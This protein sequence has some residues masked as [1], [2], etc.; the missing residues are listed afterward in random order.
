MQRDQ[1]RDWVT[2]KVRWSDM[3]AYRHV[4]NARYF[5]YLE[6]ARIHLFEQLTDGGWMDTTTGPVLA[7]VAM[8]FRLPVEYPATLEV[9][10]VLVK[11]GRSS[12]EL[13]H[14]IYFQDTE[15]LVGDGK[16]VVVW[17]DRATGKATPLTDA[18]RRKLD[19]YAAPG[20][21]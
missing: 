15:T 7:S 19:R 14:G 10:T 9:G 5:T 4:N 13:H 1:F 11:M 6:A 3:D 2:V 20:S 18:L 12:F 8:N 16:S 21:D 17:M